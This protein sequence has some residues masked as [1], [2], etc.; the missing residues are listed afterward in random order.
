M[1]LAIARCR[2]LVTSFFHHLKNVANI[3]VDQFLEP[4]QRFHNIYIPELAK[5]VSRDEARK[6]FHKMYAENIG[7]SGCV[8][9]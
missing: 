7:S 5:T 3:T 1:P 9:F 8:F 6:V 4:L 2:V